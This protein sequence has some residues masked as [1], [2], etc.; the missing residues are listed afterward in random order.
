M[1]GTVSRLAVAGWGPSVGA[2]AK[3]R[4]ESLDDLRR[5]Y[6]SGELGPGDRLLVDNDRS[7]LTVGGVR[8]FEGPG[9]Y[10]LSVQALAMLGITAEVV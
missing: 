2:M 10:E 3:L 6:A 1:A 5:A 4:Y 7:D 8:V 9:A